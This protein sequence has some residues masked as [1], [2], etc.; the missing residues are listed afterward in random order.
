[1]KDI[2]LADGSLLSV[3]IN[4]HTIKLI[5]DINLNKKMKRLEKKPKDARLQMD[6]A[7]K[8]IYVIL[9]SNGRRIDEEEAMQLIPP[10]E[11]AITEI[12]EEFAKKMQIFEKKREHKLKKA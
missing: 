2:R 12:F 3:G 5:S 7:A 9:R 4:F 8:L 6:I 1:M 10:D 11:D